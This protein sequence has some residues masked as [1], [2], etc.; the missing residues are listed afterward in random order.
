[1]K[2]HLQ[3]LSVKE[4]EPVSYLIK[5]WVHDGEQ[6][7][8]ARAWSILRKYGLTY[9]MDD[10]SK[11][12]CLI[13]GLAL[14]RSLR[15]FSMYYDEGSDPR[16]FSYTL[17]DFEILEDQELAFI[18]F[19]GKEDIEDILMEQYYIVVSTIQNYFEN[20][21]VMIYRFYS[22]SRAPRREQSRYFDEAC[23]L[24]N[25][26]VFSWIAEGCYYL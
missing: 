3:H 7:W 13:R 10:F 5:Y 24:D 25:L 22:K 11:C 15:H 1:M 18:A 20:D 9:F 8:F 17:Q 12:I 2:P 6:A 14:A 23:T 26:N 16:E 21:D 4:F 19:L